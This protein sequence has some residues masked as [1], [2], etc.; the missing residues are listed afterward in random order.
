MAEGR[1]KGREDGGGSEE[2]WTRSTPELAEVF[3]CQWKWCPYIKDGGKFKEAT[4]WAGCLEGRDMEPAGMQFYLHKDIS[5][6]LISSRVGIEC[7]LSRDFYAKERHEVGAFVR[8]LR[9]EMESLAA[10]K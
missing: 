2:R 4:G 6:S 3:R 10:T 7:M 1:K 9:T 5:Q 8:R